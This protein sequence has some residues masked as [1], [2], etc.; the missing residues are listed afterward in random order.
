MKNTLFFF[1]LS[2]FVNCNGQ[3]YNLTK[4]SND[5]VYAQGRIYFNKDGSGD[6]AYSGVSFEILT[7]ASSVIATFQDLSGPSHSNYFNVIID[8]S[9]TQIIKLSDKVQDYMLAQNLDT[10]VFHSIKIFKRTEAF[11]GATRFLGFKTT[12]GSVVKKPAVPT[13]KMLLIGDSFSCGYG[14][15]VEIQG[16]PEG[17]PNVGFTPINEDNYYAWGTIAAR[18]LNLQ[19]Q[20]LAYSGRGMYRNN[21]GVKTN[22]MPNIYDRIFPD[23]DASKKWK[24]KDYEPDVIVIKLGTNDFMY[25]AFQK[26]PVDSAEYVATYIAFVDRMHKIHPTAQII[27]VAGGLMSD[28]WPEGKFALTRIKRMI[29]EVVVKSNQNF[30]NTFCYYL[31]LPTHF[32]TYGEDWHPTKAWHEKYAAILEGKITE[33][34]QP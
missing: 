28:V 14:N 6:F 2:L 17:N 15:M 20:C 22:T 31:E 27:C 16:P 7:N 3:E 33:I 23:D 19:Y 21:T 12:V 5:K 25:E 13:K 4:A 32:G 10:T 8:D 30:G 29:N 1:V 18:V 11:V 24:D 34:I 26:I 9:I